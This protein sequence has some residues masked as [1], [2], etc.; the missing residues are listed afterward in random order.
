MMKRLI[1][2][3]SL[4]TLIC[5]PNVTIA[6]PINICDGQME[7]PPYTY[8]QRVNGQPDK[9]KLTGAVVELLDEVF[10]LIE[11][12]YTITMLPWKRCTVEV[13]NF[14]KTKKYELFINGSF[15]MER[16]KEYYLSTPIYETRQGVFYSKKKYPD[17]PPISKTS[18]IN[19]FKICGVHGY[20]LEYLYTDYGLRKDKKIDSGAKSLYAAMRKIKSG[21]CDILVNSIEPVYGGTIIG[22]YTIPP[23]IS[24]IPMPGVEPTTFH[25]FISK[26]SPRAYELL[27]KINQAIL[28]LQHNGVSKEIF[29]KYLSEK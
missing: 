12:E 9:L 21:Y 15:S 28:I 1:I 8:Y 18:D 19:N 5:L 10:N 29:K 4:F 6:Q 2:T 27:T 11:M 20:N 14:D 17:G 16:T 22:K 26:R 13:M 23:D 7:W 25:I 24:S 3:I